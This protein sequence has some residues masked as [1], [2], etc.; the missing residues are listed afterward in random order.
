MK[1]SAHK[2]LCRI[3]ALQ[4]YTRSFIAKRQAAVEVLAVLWGQ[5]EYDFLKVQQHTST[6]LCICLCVVSLYAGL[7][8][9]ICSGAAPPYVLRAH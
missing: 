6:G 7:G 1:T 4:R 8:L 3:R 5:E 2:L 9:Y